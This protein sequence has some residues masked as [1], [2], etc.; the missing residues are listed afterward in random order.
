MPPICKVDLGTTSIHKALPK[1]V[2]QSKANFHTASVNVYSPSCFF[3][4]TN[5]PLSLSLSLSVSARPIRSF[6]KICQITSCKNAL[7]RLD[8]Q[9]LLLFQLHLE[10]CG[11]DN[12]DVRSPC[13]RFFSENSNVSDNSFKQSFPW[14][15]PRFPHPNAKATSR[16]T[17]STSANLNTRHQFK[18]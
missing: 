5:Q 18:Y 9:T 14:S 10:N 3:K 4:N 1:V 12:I 11:Q 16:E 15:D 6:R 2:G 7:T 8:S 17:D 13:C